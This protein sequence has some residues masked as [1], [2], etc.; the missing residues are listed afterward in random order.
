MNSKDHFPF[1]VRPLP[2]PAKSLSPF[3][4]A[5]AVKIHHD[6]HYAMHIERL[7]RML[8]GFPEYHSLPLD[9]LI[10][11]QAF[12]PREI[13]NG[14]RTHAGGALN[15]ILF[16]E[17]LAPAS[18]SKMS[19]NFK[20]IITDSF[21]SFEKF[22]E[23][24]KKAALSIN[25]AGNAY[26]ASDGDGRLHIMALEKSETPVEH[27]L[28][29][30]FPIDMWEHSYYLQYQYHRREYLDSIFNIINWQR[31]EMNYFSS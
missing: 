30:L 11:K 26:L 7:N 6:G 4:N 15:H 5:R 1:A 12:M 19:G 29:P 31:V 9:A 28:K 8:E 13:R 23:L 14:V 24:M 17:C 3:L 25:G 18:K 20:K 16:F 27:R 2:Y 21:G 22:K 10:L